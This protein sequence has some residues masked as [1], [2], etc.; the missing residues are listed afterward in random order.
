VIVFP[1]ALIGLLILLP[2]FLIICVL[3]KRDSPGPVFYYELGPEKITGQLN[4]TLQT[5][6][7]INSNG[8]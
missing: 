3:I 6:E 1:A 2:V 4:K 5:S 7:H 8:G